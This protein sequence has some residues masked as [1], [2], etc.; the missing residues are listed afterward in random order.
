MRNLLRGAHASVRR[1]AEF[2]LAEGWTLTRCNSGHLKFS[3]AGFTPIFTS[4]TP[5]D[6]R[7]ER[8]TRALFRRAEAQ[9]S[10]S[11]EIQ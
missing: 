3:K 11:R 5:S 8:N 2:A 10:S 7:T 1:L 4:C 9:K 6:H